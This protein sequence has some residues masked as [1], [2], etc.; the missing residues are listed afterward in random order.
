MNINKVSIY[1]VLILLVGAF[2]F[3]SCKDQKPSFTD[4]NHF[5]EQKELVTLDFSLEEPALVKQIEAQATISL[6]D[7][8]TRISR[9]TVA[10]HTY[11]FPIII[12]KN[13]SGYATAHN[14]VPVVLNAQHNIIIDDAI[15]HGNDKIADKIV[16]VAK[17]RISQKQHTALLFS[18]SWDTAS[19]KD[20]IEESFVQVLL[21]ID[22]LMEDRSKEFFGKSIGALNIQERKELKAKFVGLPLIYGFNLQ[23]FQPVIPPKKPEDINNDR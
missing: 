14:V 17:E 19:S 22:K 2:I 21:G 5:Q 15:V 6:C 12:H 18:F 11:E 23:N 13:C 4:F 16:A 1:Q 3:L 9:L 10:G 7:D 8:P 20:K